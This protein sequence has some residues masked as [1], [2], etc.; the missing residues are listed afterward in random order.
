MLTFMKRDFYCPNRT[1]SI[2]LVHFGIV[3]GYWLRN[4][5]RNGVMRYL[6]YGI[7]VAPLTF[8]R[9][10]AFAKISKK[11]VALPAAARGVGPYALLHQRCATMQMNCAPAQLCQWPAAMWCKI[12]TAH[13]VRNSANASIISIHTMHF[14][15]HAHVGQFP[16]PYGTRKLFCLPK[17]GAWRHVCLRCLPWPFLISRPVRYNW[18][19]TETNK[20]QNPTHISSSALPKL[21]ISFDRRIPTSAAKRAPFSG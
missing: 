4:L 6:W 15:M 7:A 14:Q 16:S 10:K 12:Y 13:L 17:E 1:I 21:R 8:L 19:I 20:M 11:T 18:A 5:P 9:W 3:L 2:N